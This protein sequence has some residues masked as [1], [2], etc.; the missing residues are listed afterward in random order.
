MKR[1]SKVFAPTGQG[2]NVNARYAQPGNVFSHLLRFGDDLTFEPAPP[3]KACTAL[4]GEED[5]IEILRARVQ[6]GEALFSA[7]DAMCYE[8]VERHDMHVSRGRD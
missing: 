6:N 2:R 5:K 3:S 1:K 7:K 4:P 8:D